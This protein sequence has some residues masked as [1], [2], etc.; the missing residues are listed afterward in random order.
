MQKFLTEKE[1]QW[2]KSTFEKLDQKLIKECERIGN[3]S[4][5]SRKTD[6]MNRIWERVILPGGPTDSGAA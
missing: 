2:A 3:K 1:Q 5:I 6:I 4:R